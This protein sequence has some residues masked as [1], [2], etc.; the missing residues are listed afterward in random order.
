MPKLMKFLTVAL[1]VISFASSAAASCDVPEPTAAASDWQVSRDDDAWIATSAA[2]PALRL[3]IWMD[4]PEHPRILDWTV[5]ERYGGRIGVLQ[6]YSGAPGTS[7]LVTLVKNVVVDLE[8]G[9]ELGTAYFS[10]D[11]ELADWQWL[12]DRIEIDDPS[13]GEVV[14]PLE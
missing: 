13:W 8:T 4:A 11:C 6:H 2:Y 12:D 5:P 14:I 10:A 7:Y 1:C 3:E 9:T